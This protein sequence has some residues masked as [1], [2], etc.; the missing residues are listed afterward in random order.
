MSKIQEQV[1][2][3]V[4]VRYVAKR[5][6][7]AAECV[8]G[9]PQV[10]D[11]K[12]KPWIDANA[13]SA[14]AIAEVISRCPSGALQ[15]ERLDGGPGEIVSAINSAKPVN[16]GPLQFRGRLEILTPNGE[17][18]ATDTRM[19]LC[20]CGLSKNKP[21]CDNSHAKSDFKD[22]G[23][24]GS[25]VTK[26]SETVAKEPALKITPTSH[27]PLALRGPLELISSDGKTRYR[28]DRAFLCRCGASKNKPFCDGNHKLIGFS[29]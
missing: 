9:L 11:V 1:G 27:G 16:N 24:L 8:K 13:A 21:F 18:V 19:T 25:N 22:S 23:G 20:R 14:D 6:I 3:H 17:V 4:I 7:H 12:R 29:D 28:C 10:F 15:L 26:A 2:E 5:C